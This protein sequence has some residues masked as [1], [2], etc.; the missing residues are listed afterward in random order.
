MHHDRRPG[1]QIGDRPVALRGTR[2]DPARGNG[3]GVTQDYIRAH[4]WFSLAA[5]QGYEDSAKSRA[6]VAERMNSIQIAEAERLAKE[7][8]AK[9]PEVR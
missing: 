3:E 7:W 2:P 9:H 5:A 4:M 1:P 8:L 6:I